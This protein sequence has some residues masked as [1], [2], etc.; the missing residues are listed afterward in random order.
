[1]GSI[2][3]TNKGAQ[4]QRTACWLSWDGC[5]DLL[6]LVR[7]DPLAG[8]GLLAAPMNET[9]LWQDGERSRQSSSTAPRVLLRA[10]VAR[11]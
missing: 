11:P 6:C 1:M 8:A 7:C 2:S 4:E 10:G 5:C 3:P 9:M